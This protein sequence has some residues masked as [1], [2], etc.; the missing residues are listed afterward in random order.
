MNNLVSVR[1]QNKYKTSF[2]LSH[3]LKHS[4]STI[5]KKIKTYCLN[6]NLDYK[7]LKYGVTTVNGNYCTAGIKK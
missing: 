1:I 7:N 3:Y 2:S 5:D 4:H 6:N